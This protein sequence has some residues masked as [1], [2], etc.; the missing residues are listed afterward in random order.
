MIENHINLFDS[1]SQVNFIQGFKHKITIII[2][3]YF[4]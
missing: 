3:K 1:L 4:R 2:R